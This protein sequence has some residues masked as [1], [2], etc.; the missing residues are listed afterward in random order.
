MNVKITIIIIFF[1]LYF[2][3]PN[4]AIADAGPKFDSFNS[5]Y[6]VAGGI[7]AGALLGFCGYLLFRHLKKEEKVEVTTIHF[8][9]EHVD[10]ILSE[11]KM[12]VEATFEYINTSDKE[13]IMDLYFPFSSPIDTSVS[14][15]A[16]T[17][18]CPDRPHPKQ[19]DIDYKK[20]DCEILFKFKI[21]PYERVELSVGYAENI[22][23]KATYILSSIKQWKRPVA[24]ATFKVSL[25]AYMEKTKFSF[26]ENLTDKTINPTNQ[27]LEYYFSLN[28]LYPDKDFEIEWE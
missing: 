14:D 28:D 1:S 2:F 13:I 11:N 10:I 25:P 20:Q 8:E 26:E 6:K 17:L 18:N 24:K 5:H 22:Q 16:L 15:I 3:I 23:N 7:A 12:R 19:T 21:L 9:K 27:S 4:K